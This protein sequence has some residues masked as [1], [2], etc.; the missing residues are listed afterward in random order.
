MNLKPWEATIQQI[1]EESL[2]EPKES[3]RH[4]LL[5]SHSALGWVNRADPA[6]ALPDPDD[7]VREV[8]SRLNAANRQTA[9]GV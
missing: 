3:G 8:R 4:K 6:Q 9:V 5:I 1:A 2:R 7:I